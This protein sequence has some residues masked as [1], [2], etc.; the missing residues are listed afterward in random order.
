MKQGKDYI[1]KTI[2]ECYEEDRF[3]G[4]GGKYVDSTEKATLRQMIRS[5][6]GKALDLACGTGR[7]TKVMETGG[8]EVIGVDISR[9]ML[10]RAKGVE[11]PLVQADVLK[12]PF[13]DAIFD[14][15][16]A[17]RLLYFLDNLPDFLKEVRRVLKREGVFILS[18][19]NR[20]STRGILNLLFRLFKT[21]RG[22][23][24]TTPKDLTDILGSLGF[25]IIVVKQVFA[26]PL[27]SYRI[28]SLSLF[29]IIKF[30]DRIT[31]KFFRVGI[32]LSAKAENR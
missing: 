32:F 10:L 23:R 24:L 21:N 19:D 8:L 7:M 17:F 2:A 20:Y 25:G 5:K 18:T 13:D 14:V 11:S 3:S 1:Q 12:L 29:N 22:I 30:L 27:N 15:V 6:K 9:E 26:L 28:F 4:P 16:I 31:P